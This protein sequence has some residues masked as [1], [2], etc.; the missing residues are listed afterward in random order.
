ME[1]E[2]MYT[3]P[4]VYNDIEP[5]EFTEQQKEEYRQERLEW[6]K[7]DEERERILQKAFSIYYD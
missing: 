6:K 4:S 5:V 1:I 3:M 7:I 2:K